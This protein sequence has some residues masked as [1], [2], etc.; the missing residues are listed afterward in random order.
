MDNP[1]GIQQIEQK[2]RHYSTR[3]RLCS[4]ILDAQNISRIELMISGIDQFSQK[5]ETLVI[6]G[7]DD[8]DSPLDIIDVVA[9]SPDSVVVPGVA[10]AVRKLL[11]DLVRE[12]GE[13][14]I[15]H[16]LATYTTHP[17]E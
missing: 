16:K 2:R 8:P 17:N 3:A 11:F 7:S 1:S 10:T 12:Y 5:F 14:C 4:T 15:A 13:N 9:G 6:I